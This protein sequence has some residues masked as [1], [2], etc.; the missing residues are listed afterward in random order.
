VTDENWW[1]DWKGETEILKE[2]PV[3]KPHFSSHTWIALGL[4]TDLYTCTISI[5]TKQSNTPTA[6]IMKTVTN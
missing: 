5:T 1:N 2:K 3:L 4:N 6:S